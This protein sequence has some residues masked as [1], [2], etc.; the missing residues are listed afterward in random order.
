MDHMDKLVFLDIDGVVNSGKNYHEWNAAWD[1]GVKERAEQGLQ[2]DRWLD[3]GEDPYVIKLFDAENIA[4]LNEITDQ[5]GAAIVVSSSWRM[6]YASWFRKLQDTLAAAGVTGKVLAP[7]PTHIPQRG[8]AIDG[9]L[10]SNFKGRSVGMV[11]L[12]DEGQ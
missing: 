4:R 8:Q 11:I 3:P 9:F 5:T 10:Q 6:F 1:A 2:T 12:D 7:T